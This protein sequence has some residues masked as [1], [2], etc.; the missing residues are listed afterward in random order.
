MIRVLGLRLA[1]GQDDMRVAQIG[2][3]Q[4]AL[5][6]ID[7]TYRYRGSGYRWLRR[8]M[9]EPIQKPLILLGKGCLDGPRPI[10]ALKLGTLRDGVVQTLVD[11]IRNKT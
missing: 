2:D 11:M 8:L 4:L 7:A 6:E 10:L 9:L 1:L 3:D 5:G